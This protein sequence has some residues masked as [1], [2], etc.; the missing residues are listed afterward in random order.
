M[1]PDTDGYAGFNSLYASDPAT[2]NAARLVEV[3]C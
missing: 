2:G 1:S 3:A